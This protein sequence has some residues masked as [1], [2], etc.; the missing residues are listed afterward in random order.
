MTGITAKWSMY[1]AAIMAINAGND[2]ILGPTGADQV[3]ATINAL[4]AAL[5]DG[6]L[7]K[8]RLD[9]SATRIIAL[10]MQYHLVP[11]MPPQE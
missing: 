10:K 11:A 3:L 8:A 7:S 2:M 1:Q 9:E 5:Q 4:K 6:T